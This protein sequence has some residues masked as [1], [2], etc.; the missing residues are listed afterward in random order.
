MPQAIASI[1]HISD[2]HRGKDAPTSNRTML[3]KLLDDIRRTYGEDNDRLAED[4]PRLG[5]PD[6]I[7]VSGDL[8]QR[9]DGTEFDL[10]AEF[11]EG[12][13]ELVDGDRGRVVLVPGNHDVNWELSKQAYVPATERDFRNQP[14]Y[15]EPYRQTVKK[16]REKAKYWSKVE[17]EYAKRFR[18]F[19]GFFD[20]F[21]SG[22]ATPHAYSLDR[23][24]MYTVYDY[25]QVLGIVIVGFSTCDEIDH[26][27]RRAF[28]NTD[29]IYA[30]ARNPRF[31]PTEQGVLRIAVFHH[32]TRA[33]Q[34]QEDFL[35]PK[36][37]Q[38]LK[39]QGF[40]L[41]LH[42]HAHTAG[43][44]IFDPVQARTL[45]VLG[46]GSLAASY[47][48]RPPAVP[49][50][51]N[52]IVVDR[53]TAAVFAHT[54]RHDENDLIWAP[55]YRWEGKPYLTLR[56]PGPGASSEEPE[57]AGNI[58]LTIVAPDGAR[59]EG[60]VPPDTQIGHLL[61]ALLQEWQPTGAEQFQ[62]YFFHVED[63][64]AHA[65]ETSSSLQEAGIVGDVTLLLAA[66]SLQLDSAVGL[67]IEDREGRH[68]TTAVLLST[69]VRKLADAF[70]RGSPG[71]GEPVV[72][73]SGGP[74]TDAR[75]LPLSA[76]LYDE[77]IGE[78]TPLRIC[79]EPERIRG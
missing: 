29:A 72:E 65:L 53:E 54:R 6:V 26:L 13:L 8:T 47:R 23:G 67:K 76:S 24:E 5:K 77:G 22:A 1:L 33:V 30:S 2:I 52:L 73:V 42:G 18:P 56:S 10:A 55:D 62:R 12:T 50:G 20:N 70:L 49:K 16:E 28:I 31:H 79:R 14:N 45:P 4:Q 7:V 37:L 17:E 64:P 27:D 15:D 38:I 36:Y 66:E 46:S 51:Y 48:D 11:L 69:P 59:F 57:S 21:Y 63:D 68:Y 61:P 9:A 41:C 43:I 78:N 44:D 40:D 25:S 39:R 58:D 35:D 34:H 71:E 74:L 75:R 19:K 32:N 60:C 3:G